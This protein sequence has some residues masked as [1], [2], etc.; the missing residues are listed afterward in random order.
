MH[1]PLSAIATSL[2][3]MISS[4]VVGIMC[5]P[6]PAKA[7][8]FGVGLATEVTQLLN[9]AQLEMSYLKEAQTALNAIQ[10][11]KMMVREGVQLAEHPTTSITA[12][13]AT[14]NNIL[15]ASQGLAGTMAQMDRQFTSV[16]QHYNPDPALSY[17]A[18]YNKW[19]TTAVDTIR[20]A[21]NA[22]GYQGQLLGTEQLFMGRVA[23]VMNSPQGRDEALELGEVIG[24]EEV[25]QLE[26]LRELMIA[27]MSSKGAYLAQQIQLQRTQAAAQ[28]SGFG[29]LNWQADPRA[30]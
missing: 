10:M 21:I 30:W 3:L 25:A 22:A 14:L 11:A 5:A 19:A 1:K 2:A 23:A 26:K 7:Q 27:D 29:H 28:Q 15:A 24:T 12:D 17:F 6:Q 9:H 8:F 13:L 16:Y 18:A 20:G 4:P